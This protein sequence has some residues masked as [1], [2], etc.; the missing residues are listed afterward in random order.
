MK[1]S[2]RELKQIQCVCT[3]LKMASR[4]VGRIYDDVVA[5]SGIN[6]IQ[7]SILIDIARHEPIAQM[8]LA[9]HLEMERTTLYRA[10][11]VLAK[12]GLVAL[13]S[14]TGGVAK[15][16]S[17]TARGKKVTQE[18]ER[19]WGKLHDN[20]L[21]GFGVGKLEKLNGLLAEVRDHFRGT[22]QRARK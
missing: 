6:I 11:D 2:T 3:N 20:F 17:L 21:S 12:D 10:L 15:E 13:R 18:A 4:L 22:P 5:P 19:A 9:E 1:R 8:A 7:Y 14:A 16:V